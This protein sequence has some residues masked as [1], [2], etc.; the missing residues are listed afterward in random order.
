[1]ARPS[2]LLSGKAHRSNE[3]INNRKS[4]EEQLRGNDDK[5]NPPDYLT[6]SQQKIFKGICEDL[7]GS[8]GNIDIFV[9]IVYA[10]SIDRLNDIEELMNEPGRAT[11]RKLM[12]AKTIYTNEFFRCRSELC[13]PKSEDAKQEK[14]AKVNP[15][16]DAI[17][18]D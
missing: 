7:K 4:L 15:L 12:R 8:A 2:K 18:D 11:D 14:P 3:Y 16:Y 1:M 6:D 13:I 17:E 10:I 9:I 5:L